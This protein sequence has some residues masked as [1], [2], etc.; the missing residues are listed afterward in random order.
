MLQDASAE[1]SLL[2]AESAPRNAGVQEALHASLDLSQQAQSSSAQQ[3]AASEGGA[4]ADA[5][6]QET[7][8]RALDAGTAEPADSMSAPK[9][10]SIVHLQSGSDTTASNVQGCPTLILSAMSA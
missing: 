10:F 4:F 9:V 3:A 7:V 1:D 5:N 8:N 2:E 6:F